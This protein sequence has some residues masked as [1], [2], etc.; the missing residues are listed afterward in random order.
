LVLVHSKISQLTDKAVWRIANS[1]EIWQQAFG[2]PTEHKN[3]NER[4][5]DNAATFEYLDGS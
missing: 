2:Y 5:N 4:I 1:L 3:S